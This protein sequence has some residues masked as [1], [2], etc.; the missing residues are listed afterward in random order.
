MVQT[1][2]PEQ[3]VTDYTSASGQ[4]VVPAEPAGAVVEVAAPVYLQHDDRITVSIDDIGTLS[5]DVKVDGYE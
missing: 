3:R 5:C 2:K 4:R 1:G